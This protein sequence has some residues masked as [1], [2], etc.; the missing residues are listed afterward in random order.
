T[1]T[2]S[3]CSSSRSTGSGSAPSSRREPVHRS[4][5]P[6]ACWSAGG[7]R[8]SRW[9]RPPPTPSGSRPW[10]EPGSRSGQ[11]GP[12]SVRRL[13]PA[14]PDPELLQFFAQHGVGVGT[15]LEARAGSPFSGSLGVLVGGG[16]EVLP[17]GTAATDA[18]RVTP[19]G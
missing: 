3:C 10:A 18:V 5:D 1:R 17:L 14:E 9:G 7:P 6:S 12:R 13:G 16:T 4:P 19:L 2:P 15:E 8:C 11:R